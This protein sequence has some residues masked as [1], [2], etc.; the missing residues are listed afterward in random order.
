MHYSLSHK[1]AACL[2]LS[3]IAGLLLWCVAVPFMDMMDMKGGMPCGME[4][5]AEL[6][7]MMLNE[8][9]GFWQKVVMP[10]PSDY[11]KQQLSQGILHPK[12][13]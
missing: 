8:H 7:P 12:I 13:Y 9:L 4:H 5:S 1:L 3:G 2:I 10:T 11:L 6:C